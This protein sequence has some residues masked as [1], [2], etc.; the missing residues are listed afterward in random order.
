MELLEFMELVDLN[1]KSE[2]ERAKLIC[3][4]RYQ[5]FQEREFSMSIISGSEF[6]F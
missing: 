5:E 6:W 3:F 1:G 2:S 4:Y